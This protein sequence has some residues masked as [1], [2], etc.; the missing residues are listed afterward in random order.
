MKIDY[1]NMSKRVFFNNLERMWEVFIHKY[2]DEEI[3]RWI[4]D[5]PDIWTEFYYIRQLPEDVQEVVRRKKKEECVYWMTQPS[6]DL[7]VLEDF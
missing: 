7:L 2:S 4:S 5:H 6:E 3:K 1:E